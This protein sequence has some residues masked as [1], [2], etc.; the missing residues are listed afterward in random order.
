MKGE[1]TKEERGLSMEIHKRD[2]KTQGKN[3]DT[4]LKVIKKSIDHLPK[5]VL[6]DLEKEVSDFM[7]QAGF[8]CRVFS[9]QNSGASAKK[10]IDEKKKIKGN[11]YKM[12]DLYGVRIVLYFKDDIPICRK[13]ISEKFKEKEEDASEDIKTST[14]FKP[15]KLNI[16]CPIPDK[17]KKHIKSGFWEK[18]SIDA[19][20]EVQIRTVFSEGWHEI[21]HDLRYK[22]KDEWENEEDMSRAFNGILATL[23]TCDWSIISLF[24]QMAYDKYKDGNWKAMLRNKLRIRM[25]NEDLDEE[26]EKI[27][28]E[29]KQVAKEFYKLE[30]EELIKA[31]SSDSLEDV[32][33][34]M[35]NIVFVANELYVKN[36]EISALM[37]NDIRKILK[38]FMQTMA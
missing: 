24:D 16:I 28:S 29:N 35:N 6:R 4:N 12:Q 8:F 18:C 30:R 20:F 3:E 38:E 21:D 26:I 34:S 11:N 10:K 5:T 25:K 32:P 23:E 14:D 2:D 37:P 1:G 9:R 13:L 15:T 17:I 31:M 22:C 19:T 7:K 33:K 36:E 27:F